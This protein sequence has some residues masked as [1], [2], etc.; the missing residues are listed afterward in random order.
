MKKVEARSVY[1]KKNFSNLSQSLANLSTIIAFK[2]KNIFSSIYLLQ[3]VPLKSSPS[4]A[5]KF[6]YSIIKTSNLRVPVDETFSH[7]IQHVV[8]AGKAYTGSNQTKAVQ[9]F[10]D[11]RTF[12]TVQQE[13]ISSSIL[14]FSGF[15]INFQGNL[16]M[17]DYKALNS[18]L[19]SIQ[20][21][22]YPH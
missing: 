18:T 2:K 6:G 12:Y 21:V 5:R 10:I 4:D 13:T 9:K 3:R 14:N 15:E 11:S 1:Q 8:E 19:E 22:T 17:D 7:L 20:Q 16:T